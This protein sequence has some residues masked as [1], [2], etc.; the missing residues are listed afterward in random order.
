MMEIATRSPASFGQ[1]CRTL[2]AA[3]HTVRQQAIRKGSDLDGWRLA[4]LMRDA[5]TDAQ[6]NLAERKYGV[7]LRSRG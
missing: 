3:A 1:R 4:R 5:G 6:V 7:W 2:D